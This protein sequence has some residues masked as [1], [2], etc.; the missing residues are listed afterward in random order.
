[1]PAQRDGET[2][3]AFRQAAIAQGV[4][5]AGYLGRF[6]EAEVRRRAGRRAAG[7]SVDLG[8][9]EQALA[10]LAEVRASIDELDHIAGRP[11]RAVTAH[12]GSWADVGTS[13]RLSAQGARSA[14]D[15]QG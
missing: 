14:Y 8:E 12:G 9:R 1:M 5:V 2:W 4:S 10:A 3:T 6:V 11:A 15:S 13:L 7:V